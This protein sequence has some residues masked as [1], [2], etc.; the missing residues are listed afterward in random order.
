MACSALLMRS[1]L[2]FFFIDLWKLVLPIVIVWCLF[3]M[4]HVYDAFLYFFDIKSYVPVIWYVFI[5]YVLALY[6]MKYWC[7][8]TSCNGWVYDSFWSCDITLYGIWLY[9]KFSLCDITSCVI[10]LYEK[11]WLCYISS[12][13]IWLYDH[14]S[15]CHMTSYSPGVR[16]LSSS[17]FLF[18]ILSIKLQFRGLISQFS[19]LPRT[20][21][22]IILFVWYIWPH[23]LI[24][25][26]SV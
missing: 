12:Y 17:C 16:A 21:I 20:V 19:V 11:F 10:W 22:L 5:P 18:F 7:D 14:Y 25:V 15:L 2:I 24:L 6:G 9:E 13:S 23:Y 4:A 1:V 26:W 8:L 3:R